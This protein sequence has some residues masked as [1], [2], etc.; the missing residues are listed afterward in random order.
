MSQ[1]VGIYLHLLTTKQMK[2]LHLR[3]RFL[4]VGEPVFFSQPIGH[5]IL[6]IQC[7]TGAQRLPNSVFLEHTVLSYEYSLVI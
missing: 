4:Q 1:F 6:V 2:E 3:F 7:F 5:S